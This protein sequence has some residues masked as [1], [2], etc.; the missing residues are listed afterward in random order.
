MDSRLIEPLFKRP[1][2]VAAEKLLITAV[3]SAAQT[4]SIGAHQILRR[5]YCDQA[6]PRHRVLKWG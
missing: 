4:S 5:R 3:Q 6:D 2:I 1:D